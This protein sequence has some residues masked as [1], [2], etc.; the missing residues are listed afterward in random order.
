MHDDRH[1]KHQRVHA[2]TLRRVGRTFL[3]YWRHC[4]L[5]VVALLVMTVLNSVNPLVS[6]LIIDHAFPHKDL[7]LLTILVLVLIASSLLYWLINLAQSYLNATIGQRVMRDLRLKLYA[8]LQELSLRF[9]T[10][11]RTGEILS[12]LTSDVNGVEEVVTNTFSNT[13]T[14]V[15]TVLISL[16]VLLHLNAL[17]TLLFLCLLPSSSCSPCDEERSAGR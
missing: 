3:P 5:V 7:S 2:S 17:L 6:G 1:P 15:A 13:L 8:H 4:A 14:N 9:Y 16:V 12:R 10:T 11:T